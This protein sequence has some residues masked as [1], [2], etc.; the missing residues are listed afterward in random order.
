MS[1]LLGDRAK[2][3]CATPVT[4]DQTHYPSKYIFHHSSQQR[5]HSN[6]NEG[7]VKTHKTLIRR[8]SFFF[9]NEKTTKNNNSYSMYS[10]W[11]QTV[12]KQTVKQ[13]K[14]LSCLT[15]DSEDYELEAEALPASR[16]F[17]IFQAN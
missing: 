7:R 9:L 1:S 13:T 17:A 10:F 8:T 12:Y 5:K 14:S 6:F 11:Q 3:H 4:S 16:L 15:F 2:F